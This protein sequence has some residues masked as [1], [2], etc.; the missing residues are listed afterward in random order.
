MGVLYPNVLLLVRHRAGATTGHCSVCHPQTAQLR[1]DERLFLNLV[2]NQ[3]QLICGVMCVSHA[4]VTCMLPCHSG[5]A[6]ELLVVRCS[7][8][9][10]ALCCVLVWNSGVRDSR[11]VHNGCFYQLK[12]SLCSKVRSS[13]SSNAFTQQHYTSPS[14]FPPFVTMSTVVVA[15]WLPSKR[16]YTLLRGHSVCVTCWGQ[17][18]AESDCTKGWNGGRKKQKISVPSFQPVSVKGSQVCFHAGPPH[19][20]VRSASVDQRQSLAECAA[21]VVAPGEQDRTW[22]KLGFF[23]ADATRRHVTL[24]RVTINVKGGKSF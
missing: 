9:S 19:S 8:L 15:P 11:G 24:S 1:V 14:P 4:C 7:R 20:N 5:D 13:S 16:K 23:L 10:A 21:P 3:R 17:T 22:R 2:E 18:G 12:L 6:A